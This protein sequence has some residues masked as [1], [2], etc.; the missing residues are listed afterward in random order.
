MRGSD[1]AYRPFMDGSCWPTD[2][3]RFPAWHAAATA[4]ADDMDETPVDDQGQAVTLHAFAAI[5]KELETL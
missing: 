3:G 1:V 4:L 2:E 5:G